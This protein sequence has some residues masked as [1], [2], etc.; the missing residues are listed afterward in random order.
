LFLFPSVISFGHPTLAVCS[1]CSPAKTWLGPPAGPIRQPSFLFAP[2]FLLDPF[3]FFRFSYF[4]FTWNHV[5]TQRCAFS[6]WK[7]FL[8]VFSI[9]NSFIFPVFFF[10]FFWNGSLPH[11]CC[12]RGICLLVFQATCLFPR[13]SPLLPAFAPMSASP[14][15]PSLYS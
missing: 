15:T 13:L 8:F 11:N 3:F 4:A 9:S 12:V 6:P 5:S 10:F 2:T 1:G 7:V 14:A